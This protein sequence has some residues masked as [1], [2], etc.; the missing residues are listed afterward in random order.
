MSFRRELLTELRNCGGHVGRGQA[1]EDQLWAELLGWVAMC[2]P[3][4]TCPRR[5]QRAQRQ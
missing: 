3:E 5:E 1:W 4:A 2:P